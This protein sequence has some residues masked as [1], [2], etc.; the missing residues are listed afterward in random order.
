MK[1]DF[2]LFCENPSK[3]SIF[4]KIGQ[5]EW[6]LYMKT[7]IHVLSS[8]SRVV[9]CGLKDRREDRHDEVNSRFSQ[10]CERD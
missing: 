2:L 8:G 9:P 7:N 10:F 5:E 1:F 4:I 6:V 3:N